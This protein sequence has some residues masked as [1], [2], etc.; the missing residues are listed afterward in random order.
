MSK[1]DAA[2]AAL[3]AGDPAKALS[4]LQ[5]AVRDKPADARLRVFLFQLLC[6]QG[7]WD[8]ALNQL[9]VAGE[10]D[11]STAAMVQTYQEAIRCERI[12]AAVFA[13]QKTPLLFGEPEPWVALLIEALLRDGRGERDEARRL[14]ERAFDD[15]PAGAATVNGAPVEWLADGDYRL[16]PVLEAIANGRYYW[17]PFQRLS[18]IT[19]EPPAD[20]RDLV[21]APA[22]L[23][24]TNGGA[25]VAL[26]PSRYPGA[27]A[28]S[29]AA[30]RLARKT[31]WREAGENAWAG[32]GQRMLMSDTGEHPLLETREIRFAAAGS[33]A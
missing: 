32:V 21:W 22:S 15:A 33:A 8:R 3:R 4:S 23:E 14:R 20:L 13:G 30:I 9:K 28:E 5:E 18:A 10:L 12:R 7:E 27:E 31:E 6:I 2:E 19:L 25:V 17:I 26:I 11:D 16:G 1:I 29:D 24:F